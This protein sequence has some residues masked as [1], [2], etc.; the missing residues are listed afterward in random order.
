ME[1]IEYYTLKPSLRQY[2]GR[3]VNKSLK[4]DE[5]KRP[6]EVF[7]MENYVFEMNSNDKYE[8][9]T[10]LKFR[11]TLN[12]GGSYNSIYYQIDLENLAYRFKM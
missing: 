8:I 2:F 3:K 5:W 7:F 12:D 6:S 10:D 9:I 1:K 4:F 11:T